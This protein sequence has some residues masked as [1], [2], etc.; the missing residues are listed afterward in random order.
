MT[1]KNNI[2][3]IVKQSPGI[4]YNSLLNKVSSSY[5]N[6]NSARAAL[7][8]AL[9][10]LSAV[11][12]L[13]RQGNNFFVTEKGAAEINS[14]M[15]SKLLIKLNQS[16]KGKSPVNEINSIVEMLSTLIE[17]S[18]QDRDLLKAAKGSTEFY[19]SDL[20]E[21]K[22]DIDKKIHSLNYL[23][24]VLL[25]RISSLQE[26]NFNDRSQF[27]LNPESKKI[28]FSVIDKSSAAELVV[29]LRNPTLLEKVAKSFNAKAHE[30]SV[31][32][33]KTNFKKLL[34]LLEK[35]PQ[36]ARN[37]VTIYLPSLKIQ[38]DHPY[39]YLTG[40]FKKLNKLAPEQP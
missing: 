36:F 8:R 13:K 26:L 7:S 24:G 11:G 3:L 38:I 39:F 34:S 35:T 33:E 22:S 1:Q 30:N 18:K 5:G 10:D 6:V 21:L 31:T 14:E 25:Q 9:K 32:L 37:P 12:M 16:M 29:E 40:P 17:R 27:K 28:L 15:K 19:I 4:D 20:S 23:N 2:L